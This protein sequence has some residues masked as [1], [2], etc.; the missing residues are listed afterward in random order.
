MGDGYRDKYRGTTLKILTKE[1]RNWA[2]WEV[3]GQNRLYSGNKDP[4]YLQ[5]NIKDMVM[6]GS[7]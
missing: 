5:G 1:K 3:G 2:S 6:G 7:H 4:T